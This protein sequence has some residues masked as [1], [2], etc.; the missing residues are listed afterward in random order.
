MDDFNKQFE[1]IGITNGSGIETAP[2][3]RNFDDFKREYTSSEIKPTKLFNKKKFNKKDIQEF[4]TIFEY[5]KGDFKDEMQII[6]K[7]TDGFNGYNTLDNCASVS[8]YNGLLLVDSRQ[9]G[10]YSDIFKGPK[11]PET[12]IIPQDFKRSE[13]V[14]KK[15]TQQETDQQ[16]KIMRVNSSSGS[17]S[18][19]DYYLQEKQLLERQHEELREKAENDKKFI[20]EHRH[21]FDEETIHDALSDRLITSN[22]YTKFN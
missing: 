18:K 14:H 15:L 7:T 8:N 22:D 1:K 19:A 13:N 17:G 10:H 16:I 9:L 20:L 5:H 3:N 2:I 11:N 21:L 6:H 4:N 12:K